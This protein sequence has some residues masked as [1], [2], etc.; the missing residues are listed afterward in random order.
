MWS[1][2]LR[3][4]TYLLDA[5]RT[6]LWPLPVMA[7]VAA[8][9]AGVLLPR[10][11]E[12]RDSTLRPA[13]GG[14]LFGGGPAAARELLSAIAGSLVTVTSL[15]F[16]LTVVTLQLA[17]SQFSPRLLRTFARDRFV[18]STLGLF[19]ATFV[20]AITVL[21][22]VR[23]DSGDGGF[24]P[25]ISVTVSYLLV[26]AS[27][28]GLILF[29]AHLVREIR[30]ESMIYTVRT[31]AVETARTSF[32][33]LDE[34]DDET[35]GPLP[36][37]PPTATALHACST[38]FLV[39]LDHAALT[40]AAS[41]CDAVILVDVMP[42]EWMVT[43]SPVAFAWPAEEARQLD[44]DQFDTL[45]R[46]LASAIT[47]GDE[48]TPVQDVGYG[49][50]QLTD[51]AVKA[52]SPG[53][54]DPTT[55]IHVLDHSASLLCELVVRRLGSTALCDD[56]GVVRVVVRRPDLAA[57]LELAIGQP[58]HYGAAEVAVLSRLLWLL[59]EVGWRSRRDEDNAVILGQL[60]RVQ[61]TAAAQ[62]FDA[63]DRERLERLVSDVHDALAGRW[64]PSD[65][66]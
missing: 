60:H 49:L 63:A 15:T 45:R 24:V 65:R 10:L 31:D 11:D 1:S 56:D 55:A 46:C 12:A 52:L 38:G 20:Y 64:R 53:I 14:F 40:A 18:Q 5:V 62:D 36:D 34:L 21:R 58:R 41:G 3:R 51:V 48:R 8:I 35:G 44:D 42:G 47:T 17:S 37:P 30:V 7:I 61:A 50:R 33:E 59:R 26:L 57:L 32:D 25:R 39:A 66:G 29:L 19:L 6:R 23:D 16:S 4:R 27:V 22:T 9:A 13:L 28:I 2:L 43:G 54:N